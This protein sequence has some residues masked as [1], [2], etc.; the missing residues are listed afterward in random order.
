MVSIYS[1]ALF[2]VDSTNIR[3][4]YEETRLIHAFFKK[5]YAELQVLD[6]QMDILQNSL[7][8]D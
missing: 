1:P 6:N 3:V 2:T 7:L 5:D 4:G 8:H